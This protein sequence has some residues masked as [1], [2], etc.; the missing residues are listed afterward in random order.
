[1]NGKFPLPKTALNQLEELKNEQSKNVN[2][3]LERKGM[4]KQH[5]L[6][7]LGAL[8]QQQDI[9]TNAES[10]MG[11]V[12]REQVVG[13][14]VKWKPIDRTA[15]LV[16]SKAPWWALPPPP[17]IIAKQEPQT[18]KERRMSFQSRVRDFIPPGCEADFGVHEKSP[19]EFSIEILQKMNKKVS[20][21]MDKTQELVDRATDARAAIEVLS[22]SFQQNWMEFMDTADTRL[23]E[24]RMT[25]ISVD[26]E[27]RQ[28]M[29]ALRD[30]RGFFMDKD[31]EA[32]RV[33]LREFVEIC[34]RLKALKES[35]FLDTVADT[36]LRLSA[37]A[38][39][40]QSS[41]STPP[42]AMAVLF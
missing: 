38:P 30:V 20:E 24:L 39:Q 12:G 7:R 9:R 25:R 40:P 21:T 23:K 41:I 37:I 36:M 18:R 42:N 3:T 2:S 4:G 11:M 8:G 16:V 15:A 1:M 14:V 10:P 31:Y 35:G 26:T 17:P 5:G 28:I 13:G 22:G 29:S 27:V 32:E 6:P 19:D 33:R 34:E